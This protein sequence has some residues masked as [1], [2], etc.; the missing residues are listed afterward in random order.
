MCLDAYAVLAC[1]LFIRASVLV[2][3]QHGS[4]VDLRVCAQLLEHLAVTADLRF[5]D[6]KLELA[7]YNREVGQAIFPLPNVWQ[8]AMCL[9]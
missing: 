3:L 6:T 7:A 8:S 1:G 2:A 9:A 4:R 5:V